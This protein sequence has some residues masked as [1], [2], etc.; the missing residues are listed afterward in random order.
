M[1]NAE[2]IAKRSRV[3]RSLSPQQLDALAAAL[4]DELLWTAPFDSWS[5]GPGPEVHAEGEGGGADAGD[6]PLF[7][8]MAE[9]A[10]FG[11]PA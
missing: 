3:L 10:G 4:S 5:I 9:R 11:R 8:R 7:S 1:D 6:D 2:K